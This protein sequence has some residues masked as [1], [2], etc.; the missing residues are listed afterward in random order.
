MLQ[1]D[2]VRR[3]F[4]EREQFEGGSAAPGTTKNREGRTFP[5]SAL[6]ELR[7]L[8]ERRS[9]FHRFVARRERDHH[10]P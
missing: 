5:F 2:N 7:D 8:L 9:K 6:P 3:G 4:F 1:E 10:R